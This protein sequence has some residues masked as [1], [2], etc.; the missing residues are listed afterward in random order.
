[1]QT[2]GSFYVFVN[3]IICF[4]FCRHFLHIKTHSFLHNTFVNKLTCIGY[5]ID[6]QCFDNHFSF[7]FFFLALATLSIKMIALTVK[8]INAGIV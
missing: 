4:V 2:F 6:Y 3:R 8:Y 1:M 7:Q 5:L